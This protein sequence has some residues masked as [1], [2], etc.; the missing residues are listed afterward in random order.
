M[1]PTADLEDLSLIQASKYF[2]AHLRRNQLHLNSSLFFTHRFSKSMHY[3]EAKRSATP[4]YFQTQIIWIRG[5]HY[6][7]CRSPAV[8]PDLA[9]FRH[10][11]KFY[12][13]FDY[14]KKLN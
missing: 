8:R 5:S 6:P 3:F 10:F 7:D 9:K 4:I 12:K 14:F 11:G 2:E 13:V 1:G